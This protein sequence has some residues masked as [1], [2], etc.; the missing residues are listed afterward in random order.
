MAKKM[1]ENEVELSVVIPVYNEEATL[2]QVVERVKSVPLS[3]E[4]ILVDDGSKDR[5]AEIIDKLAAG[6]TVE[7]VPALLQSLFRR[8]VQGFLI[9]WMKHDPARI[10]ATLK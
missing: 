4:I 6:Q 10:I 8:S 3:M 1:G 5:S 7:D 2:E 9:S